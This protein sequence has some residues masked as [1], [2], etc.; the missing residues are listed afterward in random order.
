[1]L[2]NIS[3]PVEAQLKGVRYAFYAGIGL[4]GMGVICGAFFFAR[5]YI[6]EGWKVMGS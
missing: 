3:D 4:S 5:S 6:K 2:K 1:V